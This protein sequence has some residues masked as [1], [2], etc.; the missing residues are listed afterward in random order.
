[1]SPD[2]EPLPTP[3]ALKRVFGDLDVYLFDQLL[4]GNIRSG[5]SILDAG[6][7]H[8]RNL[9]YLLRAGFDV[10]AVDR[11]AERVA[12]VRRMGASLAPEWDASHALTAD[13]GQLPFPDGR[14]DV[15]LASAVLHFSSGP[16]QFAATL[17]E[18]WRV[19]A[20][21]GLLWTRLASSIGLEDVVQPLGQQRFR[22]PDGSDRF[23]V[24][25]ADL[26]SHGRRLGAG[27]VDP[28]KTTNVQGLRCMTTWVLGKPGTDA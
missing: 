20:P 18:L 11:D 15:V 21:D 17:D 9:H 12:A 6:C 7:G 14:F 8:G 27:L 3:E 1:M 26:L 2:A 24:S 16:A 4:R 23:L 28:I 22:L 13:L 5:M 19:L 10:H 25:E